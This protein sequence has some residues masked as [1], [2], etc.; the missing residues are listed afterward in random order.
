MSLLR[1]LKLQRIDCAVF[2]AKSHQ[3]F[4]EIVKN[5]KQII[6]KLIFLLLFSSTYIMIARDD[7]FMWFFESHKSC[8]N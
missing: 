3:L 8:Y 7:Y 1:V 5:Q 2:F 6:K 4:D